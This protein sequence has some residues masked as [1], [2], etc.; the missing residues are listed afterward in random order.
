MAKIIYAQIYVQK[1][2]DTIGNV[3]FFPISTTR[4]RGGADSYLR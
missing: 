1:A 3:I 2:D 4:K